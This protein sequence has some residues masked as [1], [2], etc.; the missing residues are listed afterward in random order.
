MSTIVAPSEL[1]KSSSDKGTGS[2]E[3]VRTTGYVQEDAPGSSEDE[4]AACASRTLAI[5]GVAGRQLG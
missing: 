1:Y 4:Q 5:H 3:V 2:D